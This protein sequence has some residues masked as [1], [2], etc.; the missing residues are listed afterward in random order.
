LRI[1]FYAAVDD[2]VLFEHVEFYRQDIQILRELGHEVSL[3]RRPADLWG[4]HD[5]VWAWWQ[6]SGMPAIASARM[7]RIPSVLVTALSDNDLSP[8]G[9]AAKGPAARVTG[10]IA[11]R[12]AN[13]V[14]ATSEDTR[15]GLAGYTTR[16]LW[17]A[18]LAVDTD[19]Y[20]PGG[21]RRGDYALCISHLTEDNVERKRIRDVV[22]AVASIPGLRGV[23]VGRHGGGVGAVRA[24]VARCGAGDRIE[25]V[26]SVTAERKL[27]L[28]RHALVYLQPTDYEAFGMAI[29]EAMACAT[30]VVSHA[31]GN[32]PDLVGD[33]GVLL[34]PGSGA[35]RLATALRSVLDD[36]ASAE[37]GMQARRR[38]EELYSMPRRRALVERALEVARGA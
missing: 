10:R 21:E 29:A 3:A 16:R 18:P 7:R 28:L 33:T 35:D 9:V 14:L 30:P 17:N 5:L 15:R 22:R 24:E 34:E 26:G 27:E 8:S 12:T 37:R 36:P 20:S 23:I 6:T 25:L 38:V 2:P 31:V 1:C 19:V 11:L 32:V 4:S 13:L